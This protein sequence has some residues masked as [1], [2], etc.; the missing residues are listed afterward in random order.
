MSEAVLRHHRF[1]SL[2][3]GE[4]AGKTTAINAIRDWLQ[5]QG[6][7]VLL[8]REPGGT[9][10]AE[11]IRELLLNNAPALQPA[12]PLAAETE[13][14]LVFAARA[15]H[16]REVIR[17]ALQRGAYVVSDRFTDSSY[18]YQGEG[19]GLDRAW[20]ADLERR[21]VGLQPG[22]T[23]LLDLDVQIGRART[24]GRDLWPDRIESEQDDFFQRVRAGFRQRAAQDP[25]R[26]RTI[27]AS[28]PP[29]A[30]AQD[31]AAALAAWVQ[32]E[33]TP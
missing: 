5:A 8:T 32:Q 12:E 4:G 21:A 10:L 14:L 29:Q 31:V 16:V 9:P 20:I 23:L 3:G 22:L 2:E 24:S 28:Q 6:H 7:E 11:R 15:Q 27:D 18:A 13:L 19:R 26:F 33:R 17:P 1:V 30:V 25:Q